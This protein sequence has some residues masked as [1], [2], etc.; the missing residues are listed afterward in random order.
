MVSKLHIEQICETHLSGSDKFVTTIK[1]SAD[2]HITVAMD[3]DNGVT[4]D[5]CV[6][7]SR[8]IEGSLN[9]EVED[10]SLDVTSHGATAPLVSARQYRK[11]VG[12]DIE[13]RLEDNSRAEGTIVSADDNGVCI[14]W[15][16]RQNKPIGKGKVTVEL[17][18]EINYN[19]IKEARIKLRF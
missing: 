15:S 12:R 16:E 11:H 10:Y 4:I 2:N 9:R 7:L 19:T 8:A 18:K 3:G 13:L 14:S 6:A 17:Q 1:I 5:D